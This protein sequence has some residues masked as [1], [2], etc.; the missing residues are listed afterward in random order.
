MADQC[1]G[2]WVADC[3]ALLPVSRISCSSG[4]SREHADTRFDFLLSSFTLFFYYFYSKKPNNFILSLFSFWGHCCTVHFLNSFQSNFFLPHFVFFFVLN[5]L[6]HYFSVSI[7]TQTDW[8]IAHVPV[9][10]ERA[11]RK[12]QLQLER[13]FGILRPHPSLLPGRIWLQSTRSQKQEIQFHFG[14]QNGRVCSPFLIFIYFSVLNFMCCSYSEKAGIAPLLDV[15]DM[16]LMARPDW[17]C[18][19]TYVQSFYRRFKDE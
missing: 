11:N 8:L 15:E 9:C 4:V 18:V 3:L 6:I 12:F 17:K 7:N 19:F 1:K 16:V 14:F 5:I 10:V 13:R 2:W